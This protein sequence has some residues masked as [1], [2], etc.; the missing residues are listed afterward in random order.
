MLSYY[1]FQEIVDEAVA[2]GK[3]IGEVILA[4]QA[5]QLN[6]PSEE[7]YRKMEASFDVMVLSLI[8]I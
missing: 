2:Q 1:S 8:H 4:D 6:C 3:K 5:A 7:I